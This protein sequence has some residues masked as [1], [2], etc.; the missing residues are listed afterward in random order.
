[1]FQRCVFID[2]DDGIDGRIDLADSVEKCGRHLFG[3][4]LLRTYGLGKIANAAV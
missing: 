2:S 4:D 1:M 3:A